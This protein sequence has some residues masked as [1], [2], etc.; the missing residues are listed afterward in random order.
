MSLE[1]LVSTVLCSNHVLRSEFDLRLS[2][3]KF[4]VS[5]KM[6]FIHFWEVGSN[7]NGDIRKGNNEIWQSNV[8]IR[9]MI[10]FYLF[11]DPSSIGINILNPFLA[12]S[13]H[14]ERF[15]TQHIH[16]I[17]HIL[18]NI[19]KELVSLLLFTQIQNTGL[20]QCNNR[21]VLVIKSWKDCRGSVA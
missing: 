20:K 11:Q 15:T 10:I 14:S 6:H 1:T 21:A 19:I 8:I 9:T 3:V 4:Y 12:V 5:E 18:Y 7:A 2:I 16:D 13:N 17:I